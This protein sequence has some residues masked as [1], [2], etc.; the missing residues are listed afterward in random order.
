VGF[1]VTFV[2]FN[3]QG[4]PSRDYKA[5]LNVVYSPVK[6]TC[7]LPYQVMKIMIVDPMHIPGTSA[8]IP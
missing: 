1:R 4:L 3:F 5:W 8:T 7:V 6:T 2:G